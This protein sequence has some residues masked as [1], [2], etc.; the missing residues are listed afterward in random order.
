MEL[1]TFVTVLFFTITSCSGNI[2][3]VQPETVDTAVFRSEIPKDDNGKRSVLFE[4]MI[5]TRN[6]L[7]GLDSLETGYPTLQFR[8]WYEY[9]RATGSHIVVIKQE[10][11]WIAELHT[12]EVRFINDSPWV[13]KREVSTA[14]PKIGWP[15]F[16]DSLI[17]LNVLTLP[18]QSSVPGMFIHYNT[19]AILVEVARK[20][21]Y[22]FYH[23]TSPKNHAE[24]FIQARKM[25]QIMLL[26]EEQLGFKRLEKF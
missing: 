16:I 18:D 14:N 21:S 8:L 9:A 26:I 24:Q 11:D 7:G 12:I 20:N 1:K 4:R 22:R 17:H 25:E 5:W 6:F 3:E 10:E 2:D 15:K 13:S 19:S 23:Y